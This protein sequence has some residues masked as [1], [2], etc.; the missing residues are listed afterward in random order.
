MPGELNQEEL[1]GFQKRLFNYGL[2]LMVGVG[3]I[4]VFSLKSI[5]Q[6]DGLELHNQYAHVGRNCRSD[7]EVETQ[8]RCFRQ[9]AT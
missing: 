8:M 6:L 3:Y 5:A 1:K 2:L 9:L 4:A 7:M